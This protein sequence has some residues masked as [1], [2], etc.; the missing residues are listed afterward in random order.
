MAQLR[1]DEH[2]AVSGEAGPVIL[3]LAEA[4]RSIAGILARGPLIPGLSAQRGEGHGDVQKELDLRTDAIVMQALR[5]TPVRWLVSEEQDAPVL[6]DAAGTLAVAIDPLDGSSN[7]ETNAPMGTIFSVLSAKPDGWASFLRPGHDQLAA[8]FLIYGPHTALVLTVGDGTHVFVLEPDTGQYL[9]AA[10]PVRVPL[11]SREYAINGSNERHWDAAVRRF[12]QECRQ[13]V[14]GPVGRDFN[15][16]WLASL[17]AEAYRI[18]RRGGVYLYPADA[19]AGYA[20]GRLRLVYEANPIAWIMEEAGGAATDGRYR[21]LDMVPRGIHQRVPLVFGAV[22]DVTRLGSYYATPEP[23][24]HEPLFGS[25]S[26]FR[27]QG[28]GAPGGV[29]VRAC[30]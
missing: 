20:D 24:R 6:L 10:E 28:S 18:L 8:G 26:L 1:L 30:P 23:A 27:G 14:D 2:P 9:E 16:R 17:V 13:G 11:E 19:R 25:R 22:E 21:I 29:G 4:G 3:A 15:T 7:I 5:R 12:A